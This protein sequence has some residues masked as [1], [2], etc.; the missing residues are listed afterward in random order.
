V[1]ATTPPPKG[2]LTIL[3]HIKCILQSNSPRMRRLATVLLQFRLDKRLFILIKPTH[4]LREIGNDP[5]ANNG[6]NYSQ[7]TL[8]NKDPAPALVAADSIH[9]RDSISQQA[10]KGTSERGG[11][12][13]EREAFLGFASFIPA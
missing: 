11:A 10:A 1:D 13:E 2:K 5:K 9:L 3:K 7:Q 6:D 12:E 4:S 8:N